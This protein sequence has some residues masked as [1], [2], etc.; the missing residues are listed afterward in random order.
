MA[1][2]VEDE[3]IET[4]GTCWQKLRAWKFPCRRGSPLTAG[5]ASEAPTSP[6]ESV[7]EEIG[8]APGHGSGR[9]ELLEFGTTFHHGYSPT[10]GVG[11][12]YHYGQGGGPPL[13]YRDYGN[14]MT[15][16]HNNWTP[17]DEYV[18]S[19]ANEIVSTTR[20]V[21]VV[22]KPE[23]FLK[24]STD[25]QNML[26]NVGS[27]KNYNTGVPE[28]AAAST[29]SPSPKTKTPE[30]LRAVEPRK[31]HTCCMA[32]NSSRIV[33][34]VGGNIPLCSPCMKSQENIQCGLFH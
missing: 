17:P 24:L 27:G 28:V 20:G 9:P 1:G 14:T 32:C 2:S 12:A 8:R 25:Q 4:V 22:M 5:A 26:I 21:E 13:Q 31:A 23:T 7:A 6:H 11:Y 10:G 18:R 16:H 33:V 34:I 15:T 3:K 30:K 19:F 29:S